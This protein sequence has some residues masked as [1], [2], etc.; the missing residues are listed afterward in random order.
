MFS[1]IYFVAVLLSLFQFSASEV[2]EGG[3]SA[4]NQPDAKCVFTVHEK[5]QNGKEL[6]GTSLNTELYYKIKCEK[7]E[8]FCLK[9]SNCTVTGQGQKPYPVI[10]AVGCTKEPSLFEHVQYVDD[11]T[12][13]IYN[14]VPIRFRGSQS[15][16]KFQCSTV[17]SPVIENPNG[18][19]ERQ[20]CIANEYSKEANLHVQS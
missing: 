13:G 2:V 1:K 18:K 4:V 9:V 6:T 7:K 16:V 12:A 15:G 17:L 8:G 3:I 14:P 11:F 20:R 10:D 19:C 5:D